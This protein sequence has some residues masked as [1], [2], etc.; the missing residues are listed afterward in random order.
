[1]E[2]YTL[3]SV[4]LHLTNGNKIEMDASLE[5][6]EELFLDDEGYFNF[7][8]IRTFLKDKKGEPCELVFTNHIVS[9]EELK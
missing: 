1:V 6:V 2:E 3:M 5:D 9:I 4:I 8:Y 7:G